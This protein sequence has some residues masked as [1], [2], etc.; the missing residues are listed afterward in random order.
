MKLPKNPVQY[1]LLKLALHL[2]KRLENSESTTIAYILD[3]LYEIDSRMS[4]MPTK[5]VTE[6]TVQSPKSEQ[7]SS[8]VDEEHDGSSH[9]PS[10][11]HKD[12]ICVPVNNMDKDTVII[13]VHSD[14]EDHKMRSQFILMDTDSENINNPTVGYHSDVM[15]SLNKLVGNSGVTVRAGKYDDPDGG[16]GTMINIDQIRLQPN[17]V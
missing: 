15:R 13:K 4:V 2:V 12:F 16:K 14:V 5:Q 9:Q 10:D 8:H 6:H 11:D 17:S 3:S 1:E 7:E